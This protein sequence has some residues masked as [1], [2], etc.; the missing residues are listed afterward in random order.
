MGTDSL[1][2][3]WSNKPGSRIVIDPSTEQPSDVFTPTTY[4]EFLERWKQAKDEYHRLYE[5]VLAHPTAQDRLNSRERKQMDPLL[6]QFRLLT[7]EYY[8]RLPIHLLARCPYCESRILQPADT[9]SLIGYYPFFNVAELYQSDSEFRNKTPRRRCKHAVVA[10]FAV[11]LNG[12]IPD[13]LSI[14]AVRGKSLQLRSDPKV[15]VWLLIARQTSAV[16]H[17]LPVGRLDEPEPIHRY[18]AYFITYFAGDDTNL[19]TEA[20]WVP[21]DVGR[22]ATEGVKFDDDLPKWVKAGRLFWLDPD[23]PEYPLVRG[24]VDRFPYAGVQPKGWYEILES[25]QVN[26][27]NPYYHPLRWQGAAPPHD[28]SFSQTIEE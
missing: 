20:M 25:G 8:R 15:T 13:D 28:E 22:P 14:W 6:Y 7:E 23:D 12:L 10:T 2:Q 1:G 11:N 24:P 3:A 27:P 17:A 9:F 16:I 5:I 18:T 26:G 19:Y 21:T 4:R